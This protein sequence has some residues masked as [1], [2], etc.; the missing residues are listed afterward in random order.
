MTGSCSATSA[1]A[2]RP[3]VSSS[4]EAGAAVLRGHGPEHSRRTG[5]TRLGKRSPRGAAASPPYVISGTLP[6]VKMAPD[7]ASAP[8]V[9][10]YVVA[11]D[12]LSGL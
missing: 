6:A 3:S 12:G 8:G 4:G 2:R 5:N 10:A 1:G 9:E 7:T 11:A